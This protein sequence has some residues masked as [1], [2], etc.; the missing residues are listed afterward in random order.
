VRIERSIVGRKKHLL[1]GEGEGSILITENA[2]TVYKAQ[3][4]ALSILY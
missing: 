1:E 4:D 2:Q 3:G